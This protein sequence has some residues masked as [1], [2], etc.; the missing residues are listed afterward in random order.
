MV[1]LLPIL[2]PL[3]GGIFV[4]RQKNEQIR[5]RMALTVILATAVLAL[6]VCLL[7]ERRLVLL[8]IQ[9]SLRLVL[10]TDSL[11]RFFMLLC[12]C[13]WVPVLLFAFPYVRH[14]GGEQRFLGFYTMILGVLMGLAMAAN[15]VTMYMFFEMMSLITVPLVL[16]TA[17]AAARRAGFKYLGYSVFGAGMA[18]IGYFFVAYYLAAPDFAAG[19]VI[20]LAKSAQHRELL[21][22]AYCLMIVGFGAKAG[23]VPMQAWLPAA[24]PVAPAPA[25][26]V[27]SGVITKGGV[28]AV[29]RVT[30]YMFGPEFLQGSWPQYVLLTLALATVFVGSMLALR[31]K[32]LKRRLAYSTVSQVSYVLF[33]LLLLTPA[34]VQAAMT[35]MVFHAIAKDTLFLA[36]G[37][38][39]FATNCT[40]VDQLQGIGK[41]MPVTMWCFTLA[42]LSLIGIPPMAGFVSKWYLV[43][44]GLEAPVAA[45]GAAGMVVLVLSALLTAG[46]LLPIVTNGFF[47]GK[48]YIADRRE[49]GP[50][51]RW[52]ML[53]FAVA[54][55]VL[56]LF[57]GVLTGWLGRLAGGLFL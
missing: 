9:G 26:A 29:I 5:N 30:Y 47:P 6:A 28:L 22:V 46:Y 14:A 24:H 44:A 53:A 52:P 49:V 33:G 54:A 55:V 15:F 20:D 4:F 12:V 45:F 40:R 8:T 38:I 41:R 10:Q 21:L 51:M 42:A 23:M 31:E 43:S 3:V 50:W 18:L 1:L 36:A 11:A 39:I 35:Q 37:A 57:P 27:L 32:Q 19:G 16:H 25:S 7:P 13:I 56:G 2:V 34:G 48:D 17:T